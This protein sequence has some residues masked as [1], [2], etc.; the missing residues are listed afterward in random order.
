MP[1]PIATWPIASF[2]LLCLAAALPAEGPPRTVAETSDYQATS[3]H[4][5]VVAFCKQLA[6]ESPLVRLSSLGTSHEGRDLPLLILA[7]P[8]LSTAEEAVKSKKL[9]VLAMA[10]IH[11]GEVDGKEALLMLARDLALA[12]ERPLL[13]DLVLVF[14]PLFN[15]DGNEKLGKHRPAQAGPPLVGT[16]ANAQALDLNRDF[17]KLESAE[18]RALVRFLNRW[19][20]A[21]VIDCHT[22][23]GSY[24]RYA[25]TYEGGRCPAG[26]DRV[27]RYVRDDLLPDVS[28][29]MLKSTRYRSFFYGNFSSDRSRWETVPPV[30][31]FGTH[32]VGL[33]NRIAILSESYSYAAFKD[34][35]LAS[36]AFVESIFEHTAQH[37]GR[38]RK[39]LAEARSATVKAGENPGE[40]DLVVLQ[41]KAVALGRPVNILGF[42][43]ESRDGKRRATDRPHSYEVQYLGDSTP[44]LSVRRPYAYLLPARLGAVVANLQR[45][46]VVVEELREAAE[47]PVEAYR[48]ERITRA[49]TFQKHRPVTLE[50]SAARERR[51]VEA[52]T[53]LVRTA[54]P[55]GS[56]AAYLLEPQSA[57]G[58]VTWNFF[59]AVLKE[60]E[61]YPVL[62]VT[63]RQALTAR[64]VRPLAGEK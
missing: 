64:P 5:D 6:K 34:R 38:V 23:N 20:P 40:K 48:V 39:L 61:E 4:A 45:H 44:T 18:V 15:A 24:H 60:K 62:R 14:A 3:R 13:R 31:R 53:I 27:I 36:K 30:P 17:V 22:T 25:L 12:K 11:A 16:R 2:S 32:Y 46:G 57:D 51:R 8:P 33:R 10:N 37:R 49:R 63:G 58:L 41:Q 55:L 1:V 59:D 7:D 26:D 9:V 29:R 50:V 42:V 35:V 21:V 54:Q 47:V 43:E 52:G 28:R 56:L 19:G